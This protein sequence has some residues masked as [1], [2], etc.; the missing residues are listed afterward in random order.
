MRKVAGIFAVERESRIAGDSAE[1][2]RIRR[3]RHTRPLLDDL[4][5]WI[6]EKRQVIP[7]KTPLGRALGYLHRRHRDAFSSLVM[8]RGCSEPADR[9]SRFH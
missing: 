7:P 9:V 8:F 3:V 5:L 6:D 2:R 1:E 4:R